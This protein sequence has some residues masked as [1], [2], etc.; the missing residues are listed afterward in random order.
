M[1][2]LNENKL[3]KVEGIIQAT[4]DEYYLEIDECKLKI[5]FVD[6][7]RVKPE[8]GDRAYGQGFY[9]HK[10]TSWDGLIYPGTL[11]LINKTETKSTVE[12][13]PIRTAPAL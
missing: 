9:Y 4:K 1:K 7:E 12:S 8:A 2:T 11:H 10:P 5:H 13:T 3:D 6:I